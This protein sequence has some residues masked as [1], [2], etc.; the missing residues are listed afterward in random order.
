M[1]LQNLIDSA[2]C[3]HSQNVSKIS[4]LMA[5]KA[6]YSR[7]EIKT[8]AQAAMLHD[9]GKAEID[10]AILNKPAALTAAEYAIVKTHTEIG[11]NRIQEGNG[12]LYVFIGRYVLRDGLPFPLFVIADRYTHET[13]LLLIFGLFFLLAATSIP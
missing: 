4:A 2:A 1:I 12:R 10:P 11:Y 8:V 13:R 5:K 7:H 6:G 9:V 3:E